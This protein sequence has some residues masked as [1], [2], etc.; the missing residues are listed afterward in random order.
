MYF[1]M[2]LI[3]IHRKWE[4]KE[5]GLRRQKLIRQRMGQW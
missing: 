1:R 2:E 3:W 4:V 5:W